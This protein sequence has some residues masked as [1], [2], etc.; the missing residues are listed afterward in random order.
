MKPAFN[1]LAP[2]RLLLRLVA[3]LFSTLAGCSYQLVHGGKINQSEVATVEAGIQRLRQLSFKTNV[4]ILLETPKEASKILSEELTHKVS[5]QEFKDEGEAG[6]LLGLYPPGIDLKAENLRLLESQV[7]AFY[8]GD[9]KVMVL[10][11]GGTSAGLWYGLT[12]FIAQRDVIGEMV[13]AHELTH[14]LQDQHF[15]LQRKLD[16]L[17]DDDRSLA[18][19]AVA[20]GDATL[21]GFAYVLG[22]SDPAII[23]KLV[24]E[25]NG[26]P[27]EF[28]KDTSGIAPGVSEPVAFEYAAGANFV[29]RALRRGGWDAVDELYKKP[30]QSTRQI[31]HPELYFDRFTPPVEVAFGC[32]ERPVDGWRKSEDNT[33]GQYLLEVLLEN[34]LTSHEDARVLADYWRGD[35][36]KILRNGP[37]LAVAWVLVLESSYAA[38]RFASTY[39]SII[40]RL[41][42][43]SS[44]HRVEQRAEKVVVI[45]GQKPEQSEKA[46]T[47]VWNSLSLKAS[48]E[49]IATSARAD[50]RFKPRAQH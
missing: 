31:I 5:D 4:P 41:P 12:Q 47:C 14:A 2:R 26:L 45:A 44:L 11:S 43:G 1:C 13:L 42:G 9:E 34:N 23:D 33:M 49:G 6:A 15:D 16:E 48:P 25:L 40:P 17:K 46:A 7:S 27:G 20:E 32:Y 3:I 19:T 28:V 18:L 21:A 35:H 29:A 38:E 37:N 22:S 36:M 10:L 39:A 50:A 8:D 24:L 30:P